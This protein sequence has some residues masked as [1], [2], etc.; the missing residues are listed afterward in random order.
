MNSKRG[1]GNEE[2]KR[3]LNFLR[4]RLNRDIK[5]GGMPF[6]GEKY[7]SHR[8]M[9]EVLDRRNDLPAYTTWLKGLV[10]DCSRHDAADRL[11]IIELVEATNT[12]L[13]NIALVT[14]GQA[15]AHDEIRLQG[16]PFVPGRVLDLTRR[17]RQNE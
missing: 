1:Y 11:G 5:R 16:D 6:E 15:G 4:E 10:E 7:P 14:G 2:G 17:R 8:Y 9:D 12:H 3:G 13:E